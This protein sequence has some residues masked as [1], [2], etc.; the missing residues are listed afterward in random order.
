MN[1][2]INHFQLYSQ[3]KWF[4]N[5]E[6]ACFGA[7]CRINCTI[8]KG[9]GTLLNQQPTNEDTAIILEDDTVLYTYRRKSTIPFTFHT[10]HSISACTVPYWSW[11]NQSNLHPVLDLLKVTNIL[12]FGQRPAFSTNTFTYISKRLADWTDWFVQSEVLIPLLHHI[13]WY[14]HISTLIPRTVYTLCM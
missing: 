9:S 5:P 14:E 2:W 7:E 13:T 3:W 12:G 1:Q 6:R 4:A 8:R 11:L 10:S